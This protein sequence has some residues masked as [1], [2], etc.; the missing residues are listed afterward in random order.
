MAFGIEGRFPFLHPS[1]TSFAER[2]T[3]EQRLKYGRKWMLKELLIPFLDS[4]FIN[5]KKRGFGLPLRY[6]LATENGKK[7]ISNSL[8]NSNVKVLF[9]Q[10]KLIDLH[11]KLIANPEKYAREILNLK[12][13]SKFMDA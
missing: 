3:S 10:K 6:F 8:I 4:K 13:L 5:R 9:T 7:L 11:S 12:M 1:I 2:F